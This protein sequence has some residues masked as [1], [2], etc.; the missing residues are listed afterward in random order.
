M[1]VQAQTCETRASIARSAEVNYF[2]SNFRA[3][4]QTFVMHIMCVKRYLR[5]FVVGNLFIH[6]TVAA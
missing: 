1:L 4:T 6:M 3:I 5:Y 2:E